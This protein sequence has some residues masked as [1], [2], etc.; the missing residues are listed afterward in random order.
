[1]SPV[2]DGAGWGTKVRGGK[3]FGCFLFGPAKTYYAY[4]VI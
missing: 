4:M 3:T 2:F 1:M